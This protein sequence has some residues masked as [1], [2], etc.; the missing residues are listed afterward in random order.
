VADALLI[1]QYERVLLAIRLLV[2]AVGYTGLW[3]AIARAVPSWLTV[4]VAAI[5]LPV[6][7][8]YRW[9]SGTTAPPLYLLIG[10]I[11]AAG[12]VSGRRFRRRTREN[13][14]LVS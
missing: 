14:R 6:A 2:L 13:S 10:V 3:F 11:G 9:L 7:E 5:W 4:A 12:A 8:H 1:G